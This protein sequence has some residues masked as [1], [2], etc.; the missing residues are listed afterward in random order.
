MQGRA[1]RRGMDVQ[2]NVI[3]LGMAWSYIENL[4][5]GQITNVTGSAIAASNDP[6]D[7]KQFVHD[8]KNLSSHWLFVRCNVLS[9]ATRLS[10]RKQWSG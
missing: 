4:M 1:G 10:L 5:L 3:Y 8:D 6:D 7:K 9:G 2:G